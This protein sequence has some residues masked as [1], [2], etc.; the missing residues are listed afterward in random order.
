[1]DPYILTFLFALLFLVVYTLY[2]NRESMTNKDLINTL[3]K[4]QRERE[5]KGKKEEPEE[6]ELPIF[7]PKSGGMAPPDPKPPKPNGK[8]PRGYGEYPD[9]YGP[10]SIMEPGTK[11][12]QRKKPG[13][14]ASDDTSGCEMQFNVD[15]RSVFPTDGPQ[16]APQPFL[17]N[18]APFQS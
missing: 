6:S 13:E 3:S 15:L 1:M 9:I 11:P 8:H 5:H 10:E 14:Q 16:E 4:R 2:Q 12:G 17:G 18:F 7:G